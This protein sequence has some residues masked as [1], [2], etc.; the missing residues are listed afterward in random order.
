MKAALFIAAGLSAMVAGVASGAAPD[1]DAKQKDDSTRVI[2][3]NI[4]EVGSRLASHRICMTSAQWAEQ[5]RLQR[6][7]T[8]RT[9]SQQ[10]VRSGQ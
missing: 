3:R 4:H 1:T 7:D 6:M 8:E 9:Q 5:R 2:C 10:S